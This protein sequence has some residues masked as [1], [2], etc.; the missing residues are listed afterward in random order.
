MRVFS[1]IWIIY[2]TCYLKLN[3]EEAPIFNLNCCYCN[4]KF[5]DPSQI[6]AILCWKYKERQQGKYKQEVFDF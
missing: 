6:Q 5:K 1:I 2:L 4:K 3:N